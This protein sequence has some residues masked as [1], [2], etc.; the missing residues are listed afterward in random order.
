[1]SLWSE[2][3]QRRIT[4][5]VVSYLVGGWI[6]VSVVDQVVDREVLPPVVYEVAFTLF[7]FGILGALIIGWYHGEKGEQ[8][9]PK[10]EI[11][12]L[13]VIGMIAVGT[14]TQVVRS[15]LAE[16]SLE[17]AINPDDLRR[18]AVLYLEDAS[19]DGSLQPLADGITE[20]L[21]TSLASVRELDVRTRNASR[22]AQPFS[23][24]GVPPRPA[25][26]ARGR[27]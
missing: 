21:I 24:H 6:A 26:C 19:R 13:V 16:A 17:D 10:I 22:E 14:S 18:I 5:I 4:Q 8:E 2:I 20:G 1:M 27:R 25:A 11:A 9:A 15:S 12:L 23:R 3:K 7:L